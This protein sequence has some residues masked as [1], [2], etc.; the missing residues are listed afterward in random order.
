MEKKI[1]TVSVRFPQDEL[2]SLDGLAS[3]C[4]MERSEF[5][6]HLVSDRLE[7]EEQI[8]AARNQLFA[9]KKKDTTNTSRDSV[10]HS[11]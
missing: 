5:I 8:W 9:A 6:R 1:V 4:S 2:D 11:A 10:G 7:K 3:I